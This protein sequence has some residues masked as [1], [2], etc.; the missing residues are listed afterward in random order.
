[1]LS[2]EMATRMRGRSLS[3]ELF[4]YS[5]KEFL[6]ARNLPESVDGDEAKA[7]IERACEAY[8]E[9]GGFPEARLGSGT[10]AEREFI[11][12]KIHQEYFSSIVQRDLILRNDAE[13]PA[14]IR[15]LTLKL[16]HDN[17]CTHSVNRL[18]EHLKA[19]GHSVSKT[20]VGNCLDW[21]HDAFLFFPVPIHTNSATKRKSN[22]NKWYCIDTG[23]V[24]S[25]ASK[26]TA[27]RGRMLENM[28]FLALRRNGVAPAYHRTASGKEIDF[29]WKGEDGKP[30]LIQVCRELR[31]PATLK[32]EASALD[33]AIR[34][35]K[36][37]Q[38]A[39]VS[40]QTAGELEAGGRPVEIVPGWR[41]LLDPGLE[42]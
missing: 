6:R 37:V 17:G 31:D 7:I 28:V 19:A 20:F 36:P 4:P 16:I 32:R 18:T 15:D 35:L 8:L 11:R 3:H 26:F 10:D 9:Q 38:A 29:V 33:E 22:P 34:E 40:W 5:F 12:T 21:M 42:P 23:M 41:F 1:M 30:R 27:D 24:R 25:V 39:I 2:K 13:H 14:A